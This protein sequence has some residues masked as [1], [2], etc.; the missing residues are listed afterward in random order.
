[1]EA[2]VRGTAEHAAGARYEHLDSRLADLP[3]IRNYVARMRI[4]TDMARTLLDDTLSA[5]DTGRADLGRIPEAL[6]QTRRGF[7]LCALFELRA[8]GGSAV[9]RPYSRGLEFTF[10]VDRDRTHRRRPGPLGR[11]DLHARHR[12]RSDFGRGCAR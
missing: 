2:A 3:T 10:G 6:R 1:M 5:V 12:S 4:K 9:L 8:P 11:S 7:R